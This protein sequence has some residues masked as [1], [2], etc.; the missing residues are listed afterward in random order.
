M[1]TP[2]HS[3]AIPCEP[4]SPAQLVWRDGRPY[5]PQY[6]DAYFGSD[7]PRAEAREVFIEANDLPRRFASGGCFAVGETGFGTGLNILLAL[8]EWRQHAPPGAFLSLLSL[9]AH[10]L[11]PGSLEEVHQHL[12]LDDA[13]ARAL[14]AQY[15]PAVTGLHRIVFP[16]AR[17]VLT[18]G[19][20][21]AAP[22]LAQLRGGIDAWFLDGFAPRSNPGLWNTAVFRQIARLSH[23]GATFGTYTAAGQVRRD[24]EAVGFAVERA[25][26]H[27]GKRER[28]KGRYAGLPPARAECPRVAV[29]GAG[30]AGLATAFALQQRGCDVRL[31]DPA[32]TG[33]GA[34]GNPAAVLLPNPH[35]RDTELNH[36]ALA[37][38]R[39]TRA[40]LAEITRQTGINPVLAEGVSFH[41]VSAHGRKRVQRLLRAGREHTGCLFD[42][43]V[44]PNSGPEP[45]LY[46][47][48]GCG[49]D[50][51]Q[52]C[53]ALAQLLPTV[54]AQR[55]TGLQAAGEGLRLVT[56]EG[57][58][59][60]PST[61]WDHVVVATAAPGTRPLCPEL[62][63][64]STV[65]GQ[66]TRI[67]APL[68]DWGGQVSTGQGYCIPLGPGEAWIGATYRRTQPPH[69]RHTLPD[70]TPRAEDDQLN[71]E[72]LSWVPGL[73]DPTKIE[74]L[75]RWTGTRAVVRDRLPLAGASSRNPDQRVWLNAAH[76]SRGLLYAPLAAE[77]L[78]DRLLGLPEPLLDSTASRLDPQ[79]SLS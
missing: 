73:D 36:L 47:P 35:F 30:L 33:G 48:A 14:R 53:T 2:V 52:F 71:L 46:Y 5:A 18:L 24:L 69:P 63:Q 25:P 28:L 49:L 38:M 60:E 13:D 62:K 75:S 54:E 39:S 68:P 10:P 32:G 51:A 67:R 23:P 3:P 1:V 66:M 79:R 22:L 44:G 4:L 57:E 70:T 8:Q 17:A 55:V 41:G 7:D 26:G 6:Q 37:G 34:S 50:L 11:S 16:D 21:D 19:L 76:G 74:T 9:E 56:E 15:P 31:F 45:R 77:L 27:G 78:A 12:G 42:L 58:A 72:H 61:P 64:V 40:L 29:V 43:E 59:N 65:S 20:G